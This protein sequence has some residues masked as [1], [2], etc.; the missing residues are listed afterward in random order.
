M[1]SKRHPPVPHGKT[2]AEAFGPQVP[3]VLLAAGTGSSWS[4]ILVEIYARQRVEDCLLVP[5]VAEPLIVWILSGS[6]LVEE[7]EPGGTWTGCTVCAGEFF[8]TTSPTPY[9]L[10]WRV[11]SPENLETLH[12]YL[13]LPM[14]ARAHEEV[15]GGAEVPR[16]REIF[17]ARDPVL[18]V[19][20][21]QLRSELLS[22][23]RPS[24]LFIQGVAQSLAVH[25]VRTYA[26]PGGRHGARGRLPAFA[27]RKIVALLEA[28]L[29]EG[30]P[31]VKLAEEAGYS[32]F[33]FSRLFK[34]TTGLSPSQYLIS[35][36]MAQ[37][38]RLLRE[39][40]RSI[41][42]VGLEVGYTN[43]SHFAQIFRREVGVTPSEYRGEH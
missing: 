42:E 34:K 18:S 37:A 35:L 6:A 3:G 32:A 7:R 19:F 20:L 33:H 17:G 40:T 36:R 30:V 9:E 24:A 1:A 15:L 8:L 5:A 38:R 16:L 28:R 31:L 13:S 41:I 14:L 4:D 2:S 21:Q 22:R 29:T 11:T 10:R 27:L 43:P 25:L 23:P 39:S 12:A 26:E